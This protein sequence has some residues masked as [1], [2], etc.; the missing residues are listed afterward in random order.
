MKKLKMVE[1]VKNFIGSIT[2]RNNTMAE[3]H[4]IMNM[5]FEMTKIALIHKEENDKLL[6]ELN[7]I[8]ESKGTNKPFSLTLYF[9]LKL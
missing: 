1:K 4:A 7:S 9:F 8:N 2:H 5:N 3:C 6:K